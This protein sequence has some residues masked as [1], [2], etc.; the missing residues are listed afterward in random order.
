MDEVAL[1]DGAV[2]RAATP[3]DDAAIA[4]MGVALYVEDPG[5]RSVT[6]ADVEKTL[7]H[8]RD[9]PEAGRAL[10]IELAGAPV[11]YA[12]VVHYWSNEHGGPIAVLDEFYVR[13]EARGR[14]LGGALVEALAW[15]RI[16]GFEGIVAV[17]LEVTPDNHRARALYER[18]GF[19]AQKN[20][21]M[22]RRVA[23]R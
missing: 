17:D 4:A 18:L 6:E 19:R 9:H 22:R 21:G 10:V 14:G 8:L 15:R 3:A 7:E 5:D 20:L 12:F 13:P 11:G 2:V 16:A 1:S 23:A